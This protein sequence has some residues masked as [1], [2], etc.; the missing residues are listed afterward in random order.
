MEDSKG[1]ERKILEHDPALKL[2][3]E[4]EVTDTVFAYTDGSYLFDSSSSSY[5]FVIHNSRGE[6]LAMDASKVDGISGVE[7][8]GL[9]NCLKT[10]SHIVS[11]STTVVSSHRHERPDTVRSRR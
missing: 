9:F 4:A 7:C 1:L 3:N 8:V 11:P 5:G 10:L 2:I 6:V